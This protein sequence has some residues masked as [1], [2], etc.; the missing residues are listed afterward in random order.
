MF[1]IFDEFDGNYKVII[2][3]HV[4]E[5]LHWNNTT[6]LTGAFMKDR[7]GNRVGLSFY[8]SDV[9]V[10]KDGTPCLKEDL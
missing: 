10:M 5:K 9:V 8:K 2:P 7:H 1:E 3:E 4:L 6:K